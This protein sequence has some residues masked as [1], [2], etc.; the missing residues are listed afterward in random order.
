ARKLGSQG[1]PRKRQT[2]CPVLRPAKE[3]RVGWRLFA[4]RSAPPLGL[5]RLSAR[6]SCERQLHLGR[7]SHLF[8]RP[9]SVTLEDLVLALD[10]RLDDLGVVEREGESVEYLR[11]TELRIPPKDPFDA[12]PV[13]VE[14]PEPANR[15]AR[16]D[17]VGATA[18]DV[19]VHTNVRV[20]NED[21]R[22]LHER[23]ETRSARGAS[24]WEP[25][26][27]ERAP[28]ESKR[29]QDPLGNFRG[30]E[31]ELV[32]DPLGGSGRAE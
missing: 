27:R 3:P 19:L 30:G 18:E 7:L 17:H 31:A 32:G 8:G 21:D 4:G 26:P 14:S 13:A 29:G 20:R 28:D 6:W 5:R 25:E 12:R 11:G 16:A 23:L 10:V 24:G 22:Q 2:A 9:L 1:R 15:H